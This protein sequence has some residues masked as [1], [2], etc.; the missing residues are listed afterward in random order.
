MLKKTIILTMLLASFSNLEAQVIS[1]SDFQQKGNSIVVNYTIKGLAI[2]Q[3]CFIELYVSLD[4]GKTFSNPLKAVSGD[5]GEIKENGN[6]SIVW[7]VFEEYDS[8]EGDIVF[9]VR[10]RVERKKVPTQTIISYTFSPYSPLGLMVGRVSRWGFY[11]KLKTNGRFTS[12]DYTL[13]NGT[14]SDYTGT[15]YYEFENS[16]MRSVYG[17]TVGGLKRITN[18]LFI[19]AGAG[20]GS[21]TKL[22]K[23]N[24]F[25]YT[26]FEKTSEAW[27]TDSNNSTSG[28]EFE[29]GAM[30]RYKKIMFSAGSSSFNGQKWNV[31]V[32]VGII[33]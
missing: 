6:K 4:G 10:A 20:Y 32:G 23:M 19:Y 11:A 13:K 15:G 5:I 28:L 14:V 2:D 21:K 12:G 33:F 16:T 27:V 22:L 3:I 31:I 29:L 8:F 30:I 26:N 24:E 17:I 25:S 1:N 18:K 7:K 9:D